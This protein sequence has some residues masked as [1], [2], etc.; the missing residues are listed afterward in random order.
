MF[1]VL[2]M[3]KALTN[4]HTNLLATVDTVKT[5]LSHAQ[6][7]LITP[8]M[9]TTDWPPLKILLIQTGHSWEF[10]EE[11]RYSMEIIGTNFVVWT[12]Y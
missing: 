2:E 12:L 6:E 4:A 3:K 5:S 10:G 9:E 7:F 8:H 1:H 11:L